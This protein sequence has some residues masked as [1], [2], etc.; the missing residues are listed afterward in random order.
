M[1]DRMTSVHLPGLNAGSGLA[2]WGRK[3][4]AEMISL[5]REHAA[6]QKQQAEAILAAS[7]DEFRVETYVGVY[8][9]RSKIVL[10]EGRK[11]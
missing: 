11:P 9:R 2:D 4:P 6:H 5:I 10:Q 1:S 8:V 7:D 3:T